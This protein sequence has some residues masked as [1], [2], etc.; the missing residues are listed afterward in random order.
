MNDMILNLLANDSFTVSDF[1]AVGL[2]AENT[3]LESEEKYLQSQM[4]QENPIFQDDQGNFSEDIF[5]Q[6][7]LQATDF[8]NK[9]AD[10]TYLEDITKNTFYSK[11]NIFA[12]NESPKIDELPRFV[13]S[14]NPFLQNNSLTRVGKR[15]DRQLSI[16]EIAQS[17][18]IYDSKTQTFKDES[19]E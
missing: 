12:P 1:R 17:Q 15:G 14:P 8:Y 6:Y 4:I 13:T 18:K 2:S 5:H 16:S 19:V 3:K 7:Y 9:L 11:D 10:E